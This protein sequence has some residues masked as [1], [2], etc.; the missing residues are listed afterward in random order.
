MAGPRSVGSWAFAAY[1]L[2]AGL[3][4]LAL[5][6]ARSWPG[7]GAP[8]G[9]SAPYAYGLV[10][11]LAFIPYAMV[12][13]SWLR[14]GAPSRRSWWIGALLVG[15]VFIVAP[16]VQSHDV[17][18]YVAYGR[19]QQM[20]EA[21]P[22]LVAPSAFP[23]DPVT[24]LLGW[25]NA[26][27]VY[28]PAWIVPVTAIVTLAD[29]SIRIATVLVKAFA[30]ALVLA[31]GWAIERSIG[32]ATATR[33]RVAAF[34]FVCNP[35]VLTSEALGGHAD[36]SIALA[37]ALA[38]FADR[39]G[40][41]RWAAF[42]L[43]IAVLVKI[44]AVLPFAVYVLWRARREG[45]RVLP[46]LLAA[47]AAVGAASYSPFWKGPRTLAPILDAG[48][49]TSSSLTGAVETALNRSI[50]VTGWVSRPEAFAAASVRVG[51]VGILAALAAWL[52]MRERT[53]VDV[54]GPVAL[55]VAGFILV[56]PWYLPWYAVGPLALGLCLGGGPSAGALALTCTSSLPIPLAAGGAILRSGSPALAWWV[57]RR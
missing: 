28:G 43:W 4:S 16:P 44:W 50:R 12:A 38:V 7:P 34:L 57:R 2:A 31:T 10:V 20:H 26:K 42:A 36:A 23:G 21:N 11:A 56:T 49:R 9:P 33:G 53:S 3:A 29:G 32:G 41:E 35:L 47:P 5:S 40:R 27:S 18:Q 51:G 54:W 1:V 17:F 55:I 24:R 6:R 52:V 45:P 46:G 39:R 15:L 48:F 37:F 13:R 22:Y 8:I 14:T 25:P 30:W 19:M